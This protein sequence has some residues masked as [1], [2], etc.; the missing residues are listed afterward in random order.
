M[1]ALFTFPFFVPYVPAGPVFMKIEGIAG[2]SR[3]EGHKDEIDIASWSWGA[4]RSTDSTSGGG[5][6]GKA[7]FQDLTFTKYVDKSTPKLM[8]AAA[9]G[10]P[11]PRVV[12]TAHRDLAGATSEPYLTITLQDVFVTSVS[13][14][15][16]AASDLPA[17][18]MSLNYGKIKFTYTPQLDDGSV[19]EP[20]DFSWDVVLNEPAP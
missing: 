10:E 11:I 2:E 16:S 5:G 4:S 12:V 6:A 7:N 9:S 15:G 14:G 20:V 18:S 3:V 17:E 1:T 13:T 19:G 8:L